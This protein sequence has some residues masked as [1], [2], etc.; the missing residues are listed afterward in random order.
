MVPATLAGTVTRATTKG[1]GRAWT[2]R[3]CARARRSGA[4][5]TRATANGTSDPI[6]LRAA[7]GEDVE[8]SPVWL[9]R[10]AGRYMAEFRAYSTKYGFRHRSETAEIAIELSMQPW[11]AYKPDG[12]IMFS[13]ILTPLPALGI[14]F[15]VVKG[16][17]PVVHQVKSMDDVRAMKTLDDP[18]KSLPFVREI[19]SSLRKEIDGQST[20]LGFIGSPWTLAAYAMEGSSDRHLVTTK[21]IMTQN[22]ELLHAFLDKLA[23]ALGVYVCYQIESGAQVVQIFDSWA[24]HLSPQQFLE[25]SHPYNERIIAYVKERHPETPLIF[26]ANGGCGKLNELKK[27]TADVIGLDWNTSMVDARAVLGPDRVLQGNMDPMYLFASPER[28]K[29]EVA[30]CV[31]D[32]GSSK[33]I[34]NVGHGVVQGTPEESVGHFCDAARASVHKKATLAR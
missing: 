17:G 10:Q 7:R 9:M 24:H 30:N 28:I 11:R 32:A 31:R 18:E 8:R 29:Q 22:P 3:G 1:D 15:D 33:H 14:E 6:L 16:K 4:T 12:V 26:H 19:L 23:D 21:Q 2:G 27:S 34:L 13:D 5:V 25:F 20:M